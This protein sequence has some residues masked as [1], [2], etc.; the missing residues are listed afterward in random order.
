M[1]PNTYNYQKLRAKFKENG[2]WSLKGPFTAKREFFLV[3][4]GQ[5]GPPP[6]SRPTSWTLGTLQA[7][8]LTTWDPVAYPLTPL[9]PGTLKTF[10][11]TLW[12]SDNPDWSLIN[13]EDNCRIRTVYLVF[14]WKP[15]KIIP[16][17]WKRVLHL[18][19]ALYY[20]C[21]VF[22]VTLNITVSG[23]SCQ[24][25]SIFEP[26]IRGLKSDIFDWDQV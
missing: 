26:I 7:Y 18:V 10:P 6:I 1:S 15:F 11:L 12:D 21:I 17:L 23:R 19:W 25:K 3:I 16:W 2:Y 5:K 8:P 22:E 14:F 4:L 9:T 20:V 24:R 13:Q